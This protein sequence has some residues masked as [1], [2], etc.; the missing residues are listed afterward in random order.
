MGEQVFLT[1]THQL[2]TKYI[3]TAYYQNISKGLKFM[4]L[5][6]F[7]TL[8]FIQGRYLQMYARKTSGS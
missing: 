5:T 2:D 6:R 3:P 7:P 8:N 4:G 1:T